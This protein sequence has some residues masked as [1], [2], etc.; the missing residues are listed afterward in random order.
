MVRVITILLSLAALIVLLSGLQ[1][2]V[3][4]ARRS[5]WENDDHLFDLEVTE[6]DIHLASNPANTFKKKGDNT[7]GGPG[8][9]EGR[10]TFAMAV[11]TITRA[12][13]PRGSTSSRRVPCLS[14]GSS[15]GRG[16]PS[17]RTSRKRGSIS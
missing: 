1:A 12:S 3:I 6:V 13:P 11:P 4:E 7:L 17:S 8:H 15:R 14:A 9:E 10:S 5:L 16:R 2:G